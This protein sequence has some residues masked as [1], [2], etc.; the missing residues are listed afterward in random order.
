M[1]WKDFWTR[2]KLEE[3]CDLWEAKP[4]LY[5][6]KVRE[7]HDRWCRKH[8][9]EE[10]AQQLGTTG[11]EVLK[12][13]KNLKT[14]YAREKRKASTAQNGC[15]EAFLSKWY[16]LP[17]LKFL[18]G[19]IASNPRAAKPNLKTPENSARQTVEDVSAGELTEDENDVGAEE[20]SRE[21]N[22]LPRLTK[23]AAGGHVAARGT[24]KRKR[25]A[26][27]AALFARAASYIQTISDNFAKGR[28]ASQEDAFD[29]FG[30]HIASELRLMEDAQMQKTARLRIQQV[31]VDVQLGS[32]QP[33]PP[34][35]VPHHPLCGPVIASC[36]PAPSFFH[37][38]APDSSKTNTHAQSESNAVSYIKTSPSP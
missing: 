25:K 18:D 26:N 31:L 8:D 16:L 4:S 6:P 2:K 21:G 14:Q 3:L 19:L 38:I 5:N 29:I 12:K 10:I 13:I 37:V 23:R 27:E 28:L 9:S 17:L 33:P 34:I 36:S 15:G 20:D 1:E 7:Y 30:K 22:P 32:A 11:E 24:N 35:P